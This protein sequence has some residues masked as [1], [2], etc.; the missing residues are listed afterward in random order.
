MHFKNEK[1]SIIIDCISFLKCTSHNMQIYSHIG[2]LGFYQT[3]TTQNTGLIDY[4]ILCL[5]TAN[6]VL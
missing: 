6:S 4:Y 5:K 2:I 1:Q 3:E